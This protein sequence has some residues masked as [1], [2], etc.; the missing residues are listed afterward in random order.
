MRG[1]TRRP[2]PLSPLGET[3]KFVLI[4]STRRCFDPPSPSDS[5]GSSRNYRYRAQLIRRDTTQDPRSQ[6]SAERSEHQINIVRISYLQPHYVPIV[7]CPFTSPWLMSADV[8]AYQVGCISLLLRNPVR[9]ICLIGM[10]V[11][12]Q[13]SHMS[14]RPRSTRGLLGASNTTLHGAGCDV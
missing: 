7:G 6:R 5:E 12:D 9:S 8:P 4:F 1:G 11:E 13:V 10:R 3:P 2:L 14:W